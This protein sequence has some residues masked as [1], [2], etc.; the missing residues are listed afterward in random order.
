MTKKKTSPKHQSEINRKRSSRIPVF[1]IIR[2]L[3]VIISFSAIYL[4]WL[5][6]RI[7]SEFE[8]KRWFLPARVYASAFEV[9]V[10]QPLSL[11]ALEKKLRSLGYQQGTAKIGLG[12]YRRSVNRIELIKRSFVFWDGE[13]ASQH[14]KV[15]FAE[16]KVIEILAPNENKSLGVFRLDP[17]LIGKIYPQHNQ[18]RVVLPYSDVPPGLIDALVAVEDKHFFSHSGLESVREAVPLRNNW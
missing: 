5:D 14:I 6:H 3:I 16:N 18:D 9:Y 11:S 13:D 1:L 7:K 17:Q 8:G 15:S 10:G 4:L 12:E 2:I